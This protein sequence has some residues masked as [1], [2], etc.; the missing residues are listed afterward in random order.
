MLQNLNWNDLD[1][2]IETDEISIRYWIIKLMSSS[3][4]WNE[5]KFNLHQI[6]FNYLSIDKIRDNV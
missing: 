1:T 4:M 6:A 3:W 5:W 2:R